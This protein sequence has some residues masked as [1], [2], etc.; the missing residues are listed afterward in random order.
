FEIAADDVP[1]GGAFQIY[2]NLVDSLPIKI[3]HSIQV[4]TLHIDYPKVDP[5][6]YSVSE[7]IEEHLI[8]FLKSEFSVAYFEVNSSCDNCEDSSSVGWFPI[9]VSSLENWGI[10]PSTFQ[11]N[12]QGYDWKGVL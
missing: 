12:S 7:A 11:K 5:P 1:P 6:E 4:A 9:Y 2:L 3:Y 10:G 8:Q